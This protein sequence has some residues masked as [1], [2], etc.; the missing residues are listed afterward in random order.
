MHQ[1]ARNIRVNFT[2]SEN[3]MKCE[4]IFVISCYRI[5]CVCND[6][7][8][9]QLCNQQTMDCMKIPHSEICGHGTC[10]QTPSKL[11]YTCICEQGWR[12]SN[13]SFDCTIDIDECTEMRPHCFDGVQCFNIP[14]SFLCGPCPTGFSGNGYTCSDIN[15]CD[16]NNGG[17]SQSPKVECI[18]TKVS[19]NS[20]INV[21]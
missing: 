7:W 3:L 8:K 15:E 18:N 17:C 21:F 16:I 10:V 14:G 20:I 11:G 5:R 13:S 2:S 1:Q 19:L 9:G 4:L 6:P 12:V